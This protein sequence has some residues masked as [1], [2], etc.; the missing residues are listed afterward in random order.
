MSGLV[1]VDDIVVT[2]VALA[3]LT[4]LAVLVYRA[5][6]RPRLLL[7]QTPEGPRALRRDVLQYA[8]SIPAL[9]SLWVGYFIVILAIARNNLS[10]FD[11]LVTAAAVVVGTR[12]L[13]HVWSDAAREIG[14]AV[15]LTIV[16]LV[17]IAGNMR[18]D[19]ALEI[20]IEDLN[21]LDFSWPAYLM[22][23]TLDY[24]ITAAWYWGWIRWGRPLREARRESATS[25]KAGTN[26]I[27]R[28]GGLES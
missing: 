13:A 22:V 15:P 19:A 10:A 4:L 24:I 20:L 17:L 18:D 5:M 2:A 12:I 8:I 27:G 14:K 21:A 28:T 11:V 3:V 1:S 7:T 6:E 9:T 26:G 23:F 25:T 16:T